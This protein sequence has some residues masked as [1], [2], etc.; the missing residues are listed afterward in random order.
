MKNLIKS[1]CFFLVAI[2]CYSQDSYQDVV[3]LKNG[4]IIH[5]II[6]EQIPNQ[7]IKI[8]TSDKNVFVFKMEEIEKITKELNNE[9]TVDIPVRTGIAFSVGLSSFSSPS[10]LS[11]YYNSGFNVRF[12]YRRPLSGNIFITSDLEYDNFSVDDDKLRQ[13]YGYG[14]KWSISGGT[15]SMLS[16]SGGVGYRYQIKNPKLG[17]FGKAELGVAYVFITDVELSYSS[18]S[19]SI[20]ADPEE[21]FQFL[22]GCGADYAVND[23]ISLL[24]EVNYCKVFTKGENSTHWPIRL[25][26]IFNL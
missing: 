6:V 22:F 12:G 1:L 2:S 8:Q 26:I 18:Y 20:S 5:G 15:I 14:T 11:D 23:N 24:F 16:I 17:V 25:G 19:Y 13:Y 9:E 3:Y 10:S 7:S 4:S 21:D